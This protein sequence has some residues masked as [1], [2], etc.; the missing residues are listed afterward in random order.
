MEPLDPCFLITSFICTVQRPFR[1]SKVK[2]RS[3]RDSG[4]LKGTRKAPFAGEI[5]EIPEPGGEKISN[6]SWSIVSKL[7]MHRLR[8]SGTS[9]FGSLAFPSLKK[10]A[11]NSWSAVQDTYFSTKVLK[12]DLLSLPFTLLS[13]LIN[14]FWWVFSYGAFDSDGSFSRLRFVIELMGFGA[15]FQIIVRFG[16][17]FF[18]EDSDF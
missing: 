17:F 13:F 18:W 8:T 5:L 11:S 12:T 3:V 4:Q 2:S 1:G 7:N 6:S 14:G 9:I 10:K 15:W 16:C